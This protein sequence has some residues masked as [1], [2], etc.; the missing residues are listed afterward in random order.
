[1]LHEFS[2]T[3]KI[4]NFA[5]QILYV[6]FSYWK[7]SVGHLSC[8]KAGNLGELLPSQ[9][10]PCR[11]SLLFYFCLCRFVLNFIQMYHVQYFFHTASSLIH[12]SLWLHISIV[13]ATFLTGVPLSKFATSFWSSLLFIHSCSGFRFIMNSL[14]SSCYEHSRTGHLCVHF[15]WWKYLKENCSLTVD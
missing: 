1:M 7:C 2:S 3:L 8:C 11:M 15:S 4:Q 12:S 14:Y 10:V 6:P 13:G 5:S 9:S